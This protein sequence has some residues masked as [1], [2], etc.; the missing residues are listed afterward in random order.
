LLRQL[1]DDRW[2]AVTSGSRAL[3]QARLE[4]AGLPSPEV[5]VSAEDVSAGKPDPAGYLQAAA[6]LGRD[7]TR[8]LVIE[9]APPGIAAGRAAGASVLAVATS[10]RGS[11]LAAADAVIP[12]LAVCLV[13][14]SADA[15]SVT[16]RS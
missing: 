10:H 7:I 14:C 11:E 6:A 1:P 3:M 2:A 15:L 8:C 9:D 13:Q 16:L 5:L 12:T 4:A